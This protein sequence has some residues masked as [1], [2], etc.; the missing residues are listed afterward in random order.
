MPTEADQ[1]EVA[2]ATYLDMGAIL[3]AVRCCDLPEVAF[4]SWDAL[5]PQGGCGGGEWTV[6]VDL[7]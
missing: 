5:G 6:T 7:N 3:D 2:V 1:G 4:G